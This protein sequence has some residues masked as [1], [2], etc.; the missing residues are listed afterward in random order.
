MTSIAANGEAP[1]RPSVKLAGLEQEIAKH[2]TSSKALIGK[3]AGDLDDEVSCYVTSAEASRKAA[4]ER[5]LEAAAARRSYVKGNLMFVA[6]AGAFAAMVGYRL[7]MTIPMNDLDIIL[8]GI[9]V[10][11]CIAG[12][13]DTVMHLFL[14]G[15]NQ[16]MCVE[17]LGKRGSE[18]WGIGGKAIYAAS[19]GRVQTV[20]LDAIGSTVI[21]DGMI[22][23]AV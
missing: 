7:S 4:T 21:E 8:L 6:A 23:I 20:R 10:V 15:D 11:C 19:V 22:V 14:R 3:A 18:V 9:A 17:A 13:M 5:F 12:L 1:A 16:A 2:L